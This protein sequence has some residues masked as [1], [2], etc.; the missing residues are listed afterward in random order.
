MKTR[1]VLSA[2]FAVLMIVAPV[3]ALEREDVDAMD[4]WNLSDLYPDIDAFKNAKDSLAEKIEKLA[5]YEGKLGESAQTLKEA[6]DLYYGFEQQMRRL[7]SYTSRRADRDTRVSENKGYESEIETLRTNLG[8]VTSY[9]DPEI[10]AIGKVKIETFLAEEPGLTVYAFPLRE[11]LRRAVHI[12]SDKEEKILAA[13]NDLAWTGYN[14]YGMLTDADMPRETIT[15]A[16]GSEI[17]LT[18]PNF[19]RVRRSLVAEDRAKA[20]EVFFGGYKVYKRTL[21]QL[22]YGQIKGHKFFAEMRGYDNTLA[23][24]LDYDD[25]DPQIYHALIQAAH[26]NLPTFH[27]Y[28]KLK[29]RALGK[30]RLDYTDMYVPF[31]R[32]VSLDMKWDEAQA[33]LLE[34]FAPLGEEYVNTIR[35]AYK[36][37]WIDVWPNEGKRSGAYSSGWAYDAHPFVLMNYNE[38]YSDALTLAHELGH[39]MHSFN[40]NANQP[41]PTSSYSTFTAEVASTFNENLLND[42]MAGKVESE[43]E[44]LYLL[45]NFLD[46]AIKGTFFRQIQFAEFELIAHQKVE[47]GEALTDEVLDKLYLDLTKKYYGHEEGVVNVPDVIATEWAAVPHFYYNYYV[48]QYSTSVAAASLLAQRVIDKEPGALEKYYANLLRAGGNA[49]PVKQLAEAGADMTKPAAYKGLMERANRYMD[50]VEKILDKQGK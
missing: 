12:L 30:E 4:T 27:R 10:I 47:A 18:Y 38:T 34:A 11:T 35:Q 22:L 23:A 19:D 29:A 49:N 25:I 33:I 6:L 15:L 17:K 50:E 44:K 40:S 32:D 24:A 37:R 42:T 3:A 28:L 16:D 14:G 43:E 20:F 48:F 9:F 36:E 21:A 41:F 26:D 13:A 2:F 39:A 5:D 46:G 1:I 8:K 7:E 45:G 31:V